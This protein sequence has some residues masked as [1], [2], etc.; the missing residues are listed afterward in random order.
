MS[1]WSSRPR[2][3]PMAGHR[4]ATHRWCQACERLHR[5][6]R[7][8]QGEEVCL[9]VET[10]RLRRHEKNAAGPHVLP[11]KA[12]RKQVTMNFGGPPR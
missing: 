1:E 9:A 10:E 4:K 11:A 6:H 5:T 2:V 3:T 7:H 12:P 8:A